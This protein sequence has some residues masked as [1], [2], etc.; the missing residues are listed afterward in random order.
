M[1]EN[2]LYI[3]PN[4]DIFDLPKEL[5]MGQQPFRMIQHSEK[6]FTAVYLP[7]QERWAFTSADGKNETYKLF[8][9]LACR[10]RDTDHTYSNQSGEENKE[11]KEVLVSFLE[12]LREQEQGYLDYLKK[13]EENNEER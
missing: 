7:K 13:K 10:I 6:G 2:E 12:Y 11:A 9:I 3:E 8:E 5:D 1:E 4:G